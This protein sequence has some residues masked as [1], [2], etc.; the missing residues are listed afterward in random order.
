M[1]VKP[2]PGEGWERDGSTH[3]LKDSG[4]V[5]SEIFQRGTRGLVAGVGG[6]HTSRAPTSLTHHSRRWGAVAGHGDGHA[7]S[8]TVPGEAVPETWPI[9]NK[10][11]R[12]MAIFED[13]RDRI[14][15][16]ML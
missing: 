3:V 4:R 2:S 9:F 8:A 14:N 11:S 12:R 10:I 15:F 1:T 5:S 6:D 16:F 13:F 7:H